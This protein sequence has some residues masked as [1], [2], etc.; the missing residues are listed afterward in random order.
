MLAPIRLVILAR[1]RGSTA[2]TFSDDLVQGPPEPVGP[3]QTDRADT[4]RRGIARRGNASRRT[5]ARMSVRVAG[6]GRPSVPLEVDPQRRHLIGLALEPGR[7]A[8]CRLGLAGNLVEVTKVRLCAD[9]ARLIP[10]A[11]ALLAK[12]LNARTLGIG[13]SVTGFVDPVQKKLLFSSATQGGPAADLSPIFHAAKKVPLILENDMHALAA[14]WLLTHCTNQQQ[15]VLLVWIADGRL[16]AAILVARPAQSG[17]RDRRQRSGPHPILRRNRTLLLRT[18]RLPGANRQHGFSRST[19]RRR[20]TC[21]V[22]AFAFAAGRAVQHA[23]RRPGAGRDDEVPDVQPGQRRQFR[24]PAS[25][26]GGER[27]GGVSRIRRCPA[28][29]HTRDDPPA[30]GRSRAVRSMGRAR[31]RLSRNRGLAGDG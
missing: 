31:C 4:Q 13:V 29:T 19:R 7:T 30:T 15:D 11:A 14:R 23:G 20:R 1:A 26:G 8:L 2:T 28:A 5:P 3:A 24:A 17:L 16:G 25:A 6:A 12:H 9:P 27:P 18:H 22:R 21:I 10:A